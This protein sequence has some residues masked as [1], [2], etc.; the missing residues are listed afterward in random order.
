MSNIEVLESIIP[1]HT[2]PLIEEEAC[3][4]CGGWSGLVSGKK[5]KKVYCCYD[6]GTTWS[7][8][9]KAAAVLGHK[10][11]IARAL[12]LTPERRKEI[13]RIARRTRTEQA[14]LKKSTSTDL[15]SVD[16]LQPLCQV[17]N[18][19]KNARPIDF[20]PFGWWRALKA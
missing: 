12:S 8:K 19:R 18:S 6:C 1:I 7:L 20:R 11:G 15:F 9:D 5:V 14:A 16:N 2:L 4:T 13:A 10:G 3:P 17:C